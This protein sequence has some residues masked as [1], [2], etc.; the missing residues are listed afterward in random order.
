MDLKASPIFQLKVM[1]FNLRFDNPE[2]GLHRWPFRKERVVE[3]VL[4]QGPDLLATQEGMPSQ[5]A[6]LA[7][8]LKGYRPSLRGRKQEE[9]GF[10]Q[11]PTIF[12]RVRS[13]ALRAG[14]EF[15][16]SETPHVSRTKSWGAAFPRLFTYGCFR[17]RSSRRSIWF[18]NT[19]L[20][21]V[22]ERARLEAAKLILWWARR[23]RLP[24]ILAGDFN[25]VPDSP[26]YR[27]LTSSQPPLVDTWRAVK[28]SKA[29]GPSTAHHFTGRP[30][31]GRIDWI[32]T[33]PGIRVEEAMVLREA[34]GEPFASDHYPYVA[35]LTIL[36]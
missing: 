1:T 32:L 24:I 23:K 33:T 26:L 17:H 35:H 11:Y 2:D 14:G 10:A 21:H 13:L 20:D 3:T 16:L 36:S 27:V 22:S 19:H 34:A 29:V 30:A 15:W 12:F 9:D 25:D 18:C 5:L 6:Y 28:G 4:S 31:G 8:K 7:E